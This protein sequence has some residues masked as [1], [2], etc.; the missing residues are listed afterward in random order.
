MTEIRQLTLGQRIRAERVRA[1]RR[2]EELA[3]AE[4][5]RAAA[6]RTDD[7]EPRPS[8]SRPEADDAAPPRP[9]LAFQAQLS[10]ETRRGLRAGY[11]V[12][13]A[14]RRTYLGNEYAGPADRRARKGRLLRASV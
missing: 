13:G 8:A 4:A 6:E 11:E 5:A 9:D 10:A 2:A 7:P 1:R 3:A 12:R 14:A